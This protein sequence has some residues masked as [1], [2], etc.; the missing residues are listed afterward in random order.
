MKKGLL[1]LL[2]VVTFSLIVVS[3]KKEIG[4]SDKATP[5][6]IENIKSYV[7]SLKKSDINN[8]GFLLNNITWDN[9]LIRNIGD[10]F[11]FVYI[12]V[13]IKNDTISIGFTILLN[14][15]EN[16]IRE[17]YFTQVSFKNKTVSQTEIIESADIIYNHLS[18][19]NTNFSGKL[20]FYTIDNKFLYNFGYSNGI[21]K[22]VTYIGKG[23]AGSTQKTNIPINQNRTLGS[24]CID[25]FFI[26]YYDDGSIDYQ[27]I[28]EDCSGC[29]ATSII[30]KNGELKA[31]TFCNSGTQ[32]TI[33]G[34]ASSTV[35]LDPF[36]ILD[37]HSKIVNIVRVYANGSKLCQVVDD[38]FLPFTTA[39]LIFKIDANN[40]LI[41][42][43]QQLII[44]GVMA[45]TQNPIQ[46]PM[47]SYTLNTLFFNI[48]GLISFSVFSPATIPFNV[49]VYIDFMQST[50]QYFASLYYH[51]TNYKPGPSG[52]FQ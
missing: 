21:N 20:A 9:V 5:F 1:M 28:A 22:S 39:T 29:T 7:D 13:D 43:S 36:L 44:S 52:I 33:A 26:T 6:I 37:V 15:K 50:G 32:I 38:H 2:I 30:N 46:M 41:E 27:L 24:G 47:D 48:Q 3:C 4:F 25:A 42:G 34:N 23:I 16:T 17:G 51:Y 31:A 11:K 12:P 10:N 35:D 14:R 40:N 18:K 8:N 45:F 19:N 49:N